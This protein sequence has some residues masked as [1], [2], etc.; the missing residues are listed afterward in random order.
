MMVGEIYQRIKDKVK[1]R[2][3]QDKC[4]CVARG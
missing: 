3:L 4:M 1:M 2:M